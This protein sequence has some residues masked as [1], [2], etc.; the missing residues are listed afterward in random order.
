[1]SIKYKEDSFRGAAAITPSDSASLT[2]PVSAIYVGGTGNI[3]VLMAS[4]EDVTFTSV[5]VGVFHIACTKVFSTSTT[6]TNLIGLK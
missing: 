5:P 2:D 3:R 1:M 4:G 6:A